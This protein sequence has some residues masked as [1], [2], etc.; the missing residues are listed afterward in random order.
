MNEDKNIRLDRMRYTKNTTAS[1]LALLAILFNVFYFISIYESDVGS[2]YYNIL[3]G[4]SIL[5]NLVFMLAAFLSSEGIK[6]YKIGY[7][8]AMIILGVIQLARI[9]IYPM[10]A[11]AAT[12]TIQ[13]QAIVVMGT[14]QFIR[15]VLY[16]A[17][18]AA[19]LFAGAVVGIIRSRA[20][21]GHL[22]TLESKAA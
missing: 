8:Y 2:W 12:V 9:F 16:L 22:A 17:L 21:A 19:C 20:L 1:G 3:I 7:S 11:H 10:R 13:E 4:A 6:N 18:S 14:A 5:Y 15:T